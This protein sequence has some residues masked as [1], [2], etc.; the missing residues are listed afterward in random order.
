MNW[1]VITMAVLFFF[2][3]IFAFAGWMGLSRFEPDNIRG[4]WWKLALSFLPGGA[5]AFLPEELT[6]MRSHWKERV[7]ERRL[8]VCG[9]LMLAAAAGICFC[10]F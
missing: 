5:W 6:A 1:L 4:G 8:L 2:G 9:V 7:M 10:V 3:S